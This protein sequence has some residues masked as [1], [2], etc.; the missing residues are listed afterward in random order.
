[1]RTLLSVVNGIFTVTIVTSKIRHFRCSCL[2]AN[3]ESNGDRQ[4]VLIMCIVA[5]ITL[6]LYA[7]NYINYLMSFR[8]MASQRVVRF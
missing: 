5:Q 4:D 6:L 7:K 2:A 3:K 8:A 1:M